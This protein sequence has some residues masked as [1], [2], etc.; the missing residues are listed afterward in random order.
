MTQPGWYPDPSGIPVQR[1]FDGQQWTEHAAP[2]VSVKEPVQIVE[3]PN[4][5]LHAVLSL[6]T[7]PLCGGWL[8][9]WLFVAI[10]DKKR[11]RYVS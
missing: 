5:V 6:L 9:V 11:V 7:F 10:N 3:G 4:H 8:W 2:L 1:Y